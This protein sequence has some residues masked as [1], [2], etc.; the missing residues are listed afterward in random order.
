[1][2]KLSAPSKQE[3]GKSDNHTSGKPHCMYCSTHSRGYLTVSCSLDRA[4][5]LAAP[6]LKR[7]CSGRRNLK[8]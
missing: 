4:P 7:L 8:E 6:R 2:N 3:S 1:M 5:I